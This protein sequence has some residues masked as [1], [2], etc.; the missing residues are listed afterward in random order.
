MVS[1]TIDGPEQALRA[2]FRTRNVAMHE[3][4][5]IVKLGVSSSELKLSLARA[6]GQPYLLHNF[7]TNSAEFRFSLGKI[8]RLVDD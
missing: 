5:L 3:Q 7:C 6:I 1:P 2:P 4:L 8:Q